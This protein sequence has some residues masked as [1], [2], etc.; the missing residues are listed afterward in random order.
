M[1]AR[2][3]GTSAG[4]DSIAA[5]CVGHQHPDLHLEWERD[6]R[7]SG[8]SSWLSCDES[9]ALEVTE[10]HDRMREKPSSNWDFRPQLGCVLTRRRR[11]ALVL[12]GRFK[13]RQPLLGRV[14]C[15]PS[16]KLQDEDRSPV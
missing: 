8:R 5:P 1:L 6:R 16:G 9:L 7:K 4:L 2:G 15:D 3:W 11:A 12:V 13:E 10:I 14:R